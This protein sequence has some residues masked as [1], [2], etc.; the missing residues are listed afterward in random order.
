MILSN[1]CK[2]SVTVVH[3]PDCK[4]V[5]DNCG[6]VCDPKAWYTLS[7]PTDRQGWV[8]DACTGRTVAVCYDV[9]DAYLLAAAP[10]LLVALEGL[11]DQADLGEVDE[12]TKP[13][14]RAAQ[15]AIHEARRTE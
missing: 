10:A 8:A 12:E 14:V 1:C 6:A 15:A 3:G 2:A 11:M 4:P 13:L 7:K 5:C 9:K